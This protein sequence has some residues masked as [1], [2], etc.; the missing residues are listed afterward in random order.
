MLIRIRNDIPDV[1]HLPQFGLAP[2]GF[3]TAVLCQTPVNM[4]TTIVTGVDMNRN[5][6]PDVLTTTVVWSCASGFCYSCPIWSSSEHR[7]DDRDRC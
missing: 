2:Q 7:H 3:A 1:L 5:D 6:N 4:D